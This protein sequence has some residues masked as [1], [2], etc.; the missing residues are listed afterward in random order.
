MSEE[1][2]KIGCFQIVLLCLLSVN[3]IIVAMN[4]ALPEFNNYTPVFYC[5]T[6]NGGNK[7]YGCIV[8]TTLVTPEK[9]PQAFCKSEYIFIMEYGE[10]SIVT[11]WGLICERNY[12]EKLS[13]IIYYVG[14]AV[15]AWTTG[16]L[17]D[18]IGR[19]PVLAI[20]LYI[21]GTITVATYSIQSYL[22][23]LTMCG[24]QGLFVQGLQNST[25]ILIME[26]LP[27][28]F[29][30][31]VATVMSIAWALGLLLLGGLSYIIPDWRI[32]Q[33]AVSV[34]TATTVLYIWIVPE[35][36]RWLL[37]K[38]KTTEADIVL[39][40][41]EKYNMCCCGGKSSRKELVADISENATPIKLERKSQIF[42]NKV[43]DKVDDSE[44]EATNLLTP[45]TSTSRKSNRISL[46]A[47]SENLEKRLSNLTLAETFIQVSEI[48]TESNLETLNT[49]SKR[50]SNVSMNSV[51]K[52]QMKLNE[53]ET[54]NEEISEIIPEKIIIDKIEI[55]HKDE[56]NKKI[57]SQKNSRCYWMIKN[58]CLIKYGSIMACQWFSLSVM[59][60]MV[61]HLIPNLVN[62]RHINFVIGS[63]IELI[64]YVVIYFILLRYGRRLPMSVCQTLNSMICISIVSLVF[65][66]SITASYNDLVKM[67]MLWL[68]RVTV[69]STLA[70]LYL[71]SVELFPTVIRGTCVGLCVVVDAIGGISAPYILLL[72]NYTSMAPL[73]FT[74]IVCLLSGLLCLILPET[75][76]DDLPDTICD[77]MKLNNDKKCKSNI[78]GDAALEREIL[79]DR[80]F[81]E[82]WVDAGNGI[83]VNFSEIKN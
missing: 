63:L 12:L 45:S 58:R 48:N 16:I 60:F 8:N 62:N 30:T 36:P 65:L 74:G 42:S 70:I 68:A 46:R 78:T 19:L 38:G 31:L 57:I 23:F 33:L 5:E 80:L 10:R 47:I 1:N 7:S 28:K 54:P 79:R 82:E 26:L 83:I 77:M 11:D 35:S 43:D 41:I 71:Y 66:P 81:S 44:T 32:L 20:C 24:L 15:G 25:Y 17:I 34:P 37:A 53:S 51:S 3:Y 9:N 52:S 14:I 27:A 61:M 55:T 2:M 56:D 76:D 4:H 18:H 39:E 72:A 29:R 50:N 40:K 21:Q 73:I 49:Q 64:I 6:S 67:F 59:K 22:V 69:A 75:L 13:V